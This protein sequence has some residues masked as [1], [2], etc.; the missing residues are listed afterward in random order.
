MSKHVV[1]PSITETESVFS[2]PWFEIRKLSGV[3]F[4]QPYYAL[5][6]ADYVTVLPLTEDGQVLFV[7]QFRPSIGAYSLEL[8]SGHV[9]PGETPE[10][11]VI[12]ELR[13]ETGCETLELFALG[14]LAPNTGRMANRMWAF[15]ARARRVGEAEPGIELVSHSTENL[16]RLIQTGELGH[17]LDLAVLTRAAAAGHLALFR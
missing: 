11:A 13:E 4:D 7:R 3:G 15:A 10:R 16:L 1:E 12:R 6:A 8:P 9:D 5:M 14:P 17:A 2:T